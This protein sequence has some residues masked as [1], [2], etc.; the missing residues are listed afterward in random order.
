MGLITYFIIK[1]V[2]SLSVILTSTHLN[3]AWFIVLGFL[4]SVVSQI[5]DIFESWLKRKAGV[6][7]SGNFIPGHGGMLD[8]IDSILLMAPFAYFLLILI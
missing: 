4:G 3:L 1:N 5:G 8:R 7:D 2:S 6:K